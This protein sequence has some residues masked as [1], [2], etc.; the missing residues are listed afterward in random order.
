MYVSLQSI[1]TCGFSTWSTSQGDRHFLWVC[2]GKTHSYTP[3]TPFVTEGQG[4]IASVEDSDTRETQ[5]QNKTSKYQRR[6]NEF[7]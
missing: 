3:V 1:F 6:Q 2:C 5:G 4:D 7:I